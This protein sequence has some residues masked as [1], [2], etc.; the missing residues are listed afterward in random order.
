M[1]TGVATRGRGEALPEAHSGLG[2]GGT[3]ALSPGVFEGPGL[4]PARVKDHGFKRC[5]HCPRMRLWEGRESGSAGSLAS[6]VKSL[7]LS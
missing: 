6:V 4:G 7:G 2:A 1:G 5:W 3:A